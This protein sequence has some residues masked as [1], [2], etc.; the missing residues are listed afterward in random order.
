MGGLRDDGPRNANWSSACGLLGPSERYE[1]QEA[2]H[3]ILHQGRT[4]CQWARLP[5]D[6][7]QKRT[8]YSC[9]ATWRDDGA[10]GSSMYFCSVRSVSGPVGRW[11]RA[12]GAGH[13][14]HQAR[15]AGG[16]RMNV[17]PLLDTPDIQ[18]DPARAQAYGLR[19]RI[20]NLQS[21][22]RETISRLAHLPR[23]DSPA[24]PESGRTPGWLRACCCRSA[25]PSSRPRTNSSRRTATHTTAAA[26]LPPAR[27]QQNRC[28]WTTLMT[29][30]LPEPLPLRCVP[31]R[32]SCVVRS[33]VPAKFGCESIRSGL[34]AV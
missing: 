11:P 29:V 31:C 12:G 14:G 8:P 15:T 33:A 30:A 5:H 13:P 2:V 32:A 34:K 20:G 3:A 7:S 23:D 22:W 16:D 9:F 24:K 28:W 26:D 19:A 25:S 1:R 6:L 4:G 27:D 18:E 10:A 17:Q 21:R